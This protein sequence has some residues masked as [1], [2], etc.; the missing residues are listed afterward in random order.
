MEIHWSD[1]KGTICKNSTPEKKTVF[2]VVLGTIG[3]LISVVSLTFMHIGNDFTDIPQGEFFFFQAIPFAYWIGICLLVLSILYAG[4]L[5]EQAAKWNVLL[6]GFLITSMRIVLNIT[7]TSFVYYDALVD[8]VPQITSW[9]HQGISFIP[10]TY[11]HDWPLSFLIAYL[12]TKAGVPVN[13]FFE[14]AAIPIYFIEVYLVYLIATVILN[15]KDV[16]LAVLLF[17]LISL[18]S[19]G[20]LL[21]LFYNPQ[22]V[23][24]TFFLLSLYLTLKLATKKATGWK[25]WSALCVSV[26]LM[27]LSHHLTVIYF[28]LTLLGVALLSRIKK[29]RLLDLDF[30]I[31]PFLTIFTSVTWIVYS[32]LV[33]Q[34][35]VSEWINALISIILAGQQYPNTY[36]SLGLPAFL[37]LPLLDLI[38]FTIVPIFIACLFLIDIVKIRRNSLNGLNKART[39]S[40]LFYDKATF[41]AVGMILPLAVVCIFGLAFNGLLYPIR[42]IAVVLFTLCPLGSIA[43]TDL[44][45]SKSKKIRILIILLVIIV[46]FLSIFWTYRIVQRTVPS[47]IARL[48]NQP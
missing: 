36:N 28:I 31:F 47:L 22:I 23:G 5:K 11:A 48:S 18:Q 34:A 40:W 25:T 33:Y 35:R 20:G 13:L 1:L 37:K 17:G 45:S 3:F 42:I 41:L 46:T 7:L 6:S 8:Y 30:K 39:I 26:F 15:K 27:I 44:L 29:S 38:S 19:E 14:W 43:L 16:S 10:G 21:T 2:V 9:L 32:F 12:F 24:G 4:Y